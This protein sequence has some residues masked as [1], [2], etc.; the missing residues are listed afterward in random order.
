MRFNRIRRTVNL[1]VAALLLFLFIVPGLY[2][3]RTTDAMLRFV[4]AAEQAALSGDL[5]LA[6]RELSA[7]SETTREK[8]PVCKLLLDHGAVDALLTAVEA[9]APLSEREDLLVAA[10]GLRCGVEQLRE[11]ELFSLKTLR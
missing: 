8:L 2:L 6:Q 1:I 5:P 9:A 11:I 4:N 3:S 7:L 10:A